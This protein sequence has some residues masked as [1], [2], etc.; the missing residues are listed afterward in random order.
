MP[1]EKVVGDVERCDHFVTGELV[2]GPEGDLLQVDI[3]TDT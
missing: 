1:Q 3:R 2:H